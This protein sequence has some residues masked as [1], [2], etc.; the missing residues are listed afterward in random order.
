MNV[1][2]EDTG[3]ELHPKRQVLIKFLL[4]CLL[5]VLYFAYLWWKFD[6]L[7][8]GVAAALTWSFLVLCTPVADGGF[9]LDFPLRLL[10][11]I[12]MV[13]SEIFVWGV[14]IAIN[15][16]TMI[17]GVSYYETT[18]VTRILY[19]ILL[20]PYPYWAIIGLA[21]AGTFISIRF[22][23][24]LMDVVRHRDRIYFHRR[25]FTFELIML[26]FFIFVIW[27]YYELISSLGIDLNL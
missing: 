26:A 19:K 20:T 25:A 7:T 6:A 23:D 3:K 17:F 22:G 21:M 5:L 15:I 12:R 18:M 14:A 1:K 16:A 10:F 27:A 8:G 4:L 2:A 11:G 9:L 13:I 24:E